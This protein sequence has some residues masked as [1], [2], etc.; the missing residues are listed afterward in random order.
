LIMQLKR[1]NSR[2]NRLA[3]GALSLPAP[4][5]SAFERKEGCGPRQWPAKLAAAACAVNYR[6]AHAHS[7]SQFDCVEH[8]AHRVDRGWLLETSGLTET[9]GPCVRNKSHP[10]HGANPLPA[11]QLATHFSRAAACRTDP[12]GASRVSCPSRVQRR[13]QRRTVHL[14]SVWIAGGALRERLAPGTDRSCATGA[15]GSGPSHQSLAGCAPAGRCEGHGWAAW[16]AVDPAAPAVRTFAGC[17]RR[18]RT[19]G[20]GARSPDRRADFDGRPIGSVRRG[21]AARSR[22]SPAAA[23]G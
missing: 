18:R 11:D 4:Q 16:N 3:G 17:R 22:T 9:P 10:A 5:R 21:H 13:A 19:K 1:A 7:G 14:R 12:S 8:A 15:A 20:A 23:Q 6:L 2:G